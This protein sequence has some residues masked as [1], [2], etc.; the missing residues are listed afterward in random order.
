MGALLFWS[1]ILG[2]LVDLDKSIFAFINQNL[3]NPIFDLIMPFVTRLDHFK[4]PFVLLGIALLIW[5][6]R[7]GRVALI[8]VLLAVAY[9]DLLSSQVIKPWVERLRPCAALE[10]VRMLIGKKTSLSFP[11]SHAA[12]ITAAAVVFSYYYPKAKWALAGI[13]LMICFS[14]VYV[15]VHY[16]MDV[17]A[18]ALIGGA[19]ASVVLLAMEQMAPIKS[20]STLDPPKPEK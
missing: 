9:S 19:M 16:P 8:A 18:G 13:A 15:G 1:W 10:G 11:S 14:R 7:R 17:L 20:E 5:G 4:I 12:N 2:T 3:A 6:K